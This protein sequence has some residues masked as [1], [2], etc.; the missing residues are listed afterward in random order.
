MQPGSTEAASKPTLK[1]LEKNYNSAVQKLFFWSSLND[2]FSLGSLIADIS[3]KVYDE[4]KSLTLSSERKYSKT[5]FVD[6]V[7]TITK[8]RCGKEIEKILS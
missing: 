7:T 2:Q 8:K 4:Y 1:S 6:K 5:D 3:S